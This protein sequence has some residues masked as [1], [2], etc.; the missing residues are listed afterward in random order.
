MKNIFYCQ[1]YHHYVL[2]VHCS[3]DKPFTLTGYMN[4]VRKNI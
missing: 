3:D 2:D 1:L 4:G